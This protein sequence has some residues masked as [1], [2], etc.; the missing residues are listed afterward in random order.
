MRSAEYELNDR[1]RGCLRW[2]VQSVAPEV[3][4]AVGSKEKFS[5]DVDVGSYHVTV[6]RLEMKVDL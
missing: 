5:F 4:G 6:P 2:D 1:V 3:E